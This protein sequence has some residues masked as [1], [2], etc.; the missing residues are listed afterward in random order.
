MS[1]LTEE[2]VK[3]LF[4]ASGFEIKKIYIL[5]NKYWPDNEHK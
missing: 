3:G 1:Q 4:I 2:Q 5:V